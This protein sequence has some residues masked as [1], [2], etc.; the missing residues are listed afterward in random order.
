LHLD[1]RA[2]VQGQRGEHL[3]IEGTKT[4]GSTRDFTRER[5]EQ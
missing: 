3:H 1:D 2:L 5:E 4:E